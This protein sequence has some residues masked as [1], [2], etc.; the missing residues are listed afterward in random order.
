MSILSKV[1]INSY[2]C[3]HYLLKSESTYSLIQN[4]K[5]S[6]QNQIN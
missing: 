4:F 1:N 6:I 3:F 5:S 2:E